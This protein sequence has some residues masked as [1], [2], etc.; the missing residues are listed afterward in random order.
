MLRVGVTIKQIENKHLQ[1]FNNFTS[2]NHLGEHKKNFG[3]HC[4][5]CPPVAMGLCH[6]AKLC[7]DAARD[8]RSQQY[9]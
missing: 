4:P 2:L 5:E 1:K 7:L 8:F 9:Q 6:S 3:R